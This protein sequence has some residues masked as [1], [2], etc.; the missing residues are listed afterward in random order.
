[1]LQRYGRLDQ[2]RLDLSR[3]R[4]LIGCG[5]CGAALIALV[6]LLGCGGEDGASA[7]DTATGA[8]GDGATLDTGA[9]SDAGGDGASGAT[10]D[11]SSDAQGA[12]DTGPVCHPIKNTGCPTGQHCVYS[13]D[14]ILCEDDGAHGVGEACDDGKGCKVGI[15]LKPKAGESR[16]APFCTVDV[17]CASGSCNTLEG[18]KGKA[19]DMGG[20]QLTPCDILAQDCKEAGTACYATSHGFGCLKAGI[21]AVGEACSDED[22]CKKGV[23]CTGLAG[24]GNGIRT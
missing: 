16:C 6:L 8:G 18:S 7:T 13:G 9:K 10:A 23:A 22:G 24:V 11:G 4:P 17:Q 21:A 20:T 15:C 12:G 3:A 5:P 19:C 1:M 14:L 2:P